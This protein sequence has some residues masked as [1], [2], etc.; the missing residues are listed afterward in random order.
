MKGLQTRTQLHSLPVKINDAWGYAACVACCPALSQV[1]MCLRKERVLEREGIEVCCW[2]LPHTQQE[3]L[4]KARPY[5]QGTPD[6]AMHTAFLS[7]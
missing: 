2:I 6:Q 3:L 4:V 1:G 7:T 5:I